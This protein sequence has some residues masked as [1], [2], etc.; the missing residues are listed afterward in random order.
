VLNNKPLYALNQAPN[1]IPAKPANTHN[2]EHKRRDDGAQGYHFQRARE[3]SVTL[4]TLAGR[5]VTGLL[6]SF[7]R[8][9]LVLSNGPKRTVFFK[10]GL[11]SLEYHDQEQ[12]LRR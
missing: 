6:V 10:H 7:D 11:L 8:F 5:E 2:Q 1:R 9:A 4:T 12:G 3:K